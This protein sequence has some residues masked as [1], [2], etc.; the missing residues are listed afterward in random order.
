MDLNSEERLS[1]FGSPTGGGGFCYSLG[2]PVPDPRSESLHIRPGGETGRPYHTPLPRR[3][4][5]KTAVGERCEQ[6]VC[7]P[8]GRPQNNDN[9]RLKDASSCPTW[10]I[11]N[12]KAIF[13]TIRPDL[14]KYKREQTCAEQTQK[15]TQPPA[16][17]TSDRWIRAKV[18][19]SL[20]ICN[21]LQSWQS[22]AGNCHMAALCVGH[23]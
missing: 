17:V 6:G 5:V 14:S 11:C 22:V 3:L 7:V 13:N 18:P 16:W 2:Q 1:L 9:L 10:T 20:I 19:N 4:A 12:F 21:L 8:D 23:L 15:S